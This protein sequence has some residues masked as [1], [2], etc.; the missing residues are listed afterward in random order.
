MAGKA[1][2]DLRGA[3]DAVKK[4]VPDAVLHDAVVTS[5][6]VVVFALECQPFLYHNKKLSGLN[7]NYDPHIRIIEEAYELMSHG[8]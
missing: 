2:N 3:I 1:V 4:A 6:G 5:K 8:S 7:P